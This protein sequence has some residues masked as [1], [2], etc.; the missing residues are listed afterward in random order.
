RPSPRIPVLPRISSRTASRRSAASASTE[1]P[2]DLR[3]HGFRAR[4]LSIC[5]HT[6]VRFRQRE[7]SKGEHA[8][9][10]VSDNAAEPL[11]L[12]RYALHDQIAAGGMATVHVGRLLGPVGF[13]R[14]CAI[15]RLYPEF[16]HDREFVAMFL[17]EARLASRVRHA[18]VVTTLDI[19]T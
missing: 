8:E 5:P 7:R 17:D 10:T 13:A 14:T 2:P 9:M 15:K 12:G 11:V 1:C 3:P 19:V 4:S 18:N 16:A 6:L